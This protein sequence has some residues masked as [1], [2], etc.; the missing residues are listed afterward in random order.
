MK[1]AVTKGHWVIVGH[2]PLETSLRNAPLQFMQDRLQPE[3]FSIYENGKTRLATREQCV[4]LESRGQVHFSAFT[5]RLIG[6]EPD[7]QR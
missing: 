6:I 2:L 5:L 3:Q 1:Y 4:E 7:N